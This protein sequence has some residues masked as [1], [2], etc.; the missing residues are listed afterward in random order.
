MRLIEF[1]Q[2]YDRQVEDTR[3]S[4]L[5]ETFRCT[6]GVPSNAKKSTRLLLYKENL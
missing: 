2:H 3:S 6:N 4:E 1:V 5:E